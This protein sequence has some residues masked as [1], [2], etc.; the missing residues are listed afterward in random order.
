MIFDGS[1][2]TSM[3]LNIN[4]DDYGPETSEPVPEFPGLT[5]MTLS[6]VTHKLA[7]TFRKLLFPSQISVTEKEQ[8]VKSLALNLS[9]STFRSVTQTFPFSGFFQ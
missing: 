2:D 7:F 1:F 4:D 9:H 5:D 6:H 3:P 8:M